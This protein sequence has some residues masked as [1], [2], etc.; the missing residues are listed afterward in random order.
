MSYTLLLWINVINAVGDTGNDKVT[1]RSTNVSVNVKWC[2]KLVHQ[3][4]I[5]TTI[6][7]WVS[8]FRMSIVLYCINVLFSKSCGTEDSECQTNNSIYQAF[9]NTN[10]CKSY[11]VCDHGIKVLR[12]CEAGTWF[13][14]DQ[15]VSF[16]YFN[17]WRCLF[18]QMIF[19]WFFIKECV[20]PKSSGCKPLKKQTEF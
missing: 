20:P 9:P 1:L 18:N 4:P 10:D 3:I 16:T 19:I 13:N 11:Y 8:I 7:M 2:F 5:I 17:C 14:A 6:S 15:Q 12:Q